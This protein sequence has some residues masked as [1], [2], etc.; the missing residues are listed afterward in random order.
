MSDDDLEDIA[1][2]NCPVD[3]VPMV[4]EGDKAPRWVCQQCG[5]VQL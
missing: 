4:A 3:L 5:L 1:A 2:P